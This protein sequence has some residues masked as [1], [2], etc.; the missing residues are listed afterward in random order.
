MPTGRANARQLYHEGARKVNALAPPLSLCPVARL[1][2]G[3]G[4]VCD[5]SP[6]TQHT[7]GWR[8]TVSEKS[9]AHWWSHEVWRG[10]P[11]AESEEDIGFL[12]M[13]KELTSQSSGSP[14]SL[15]IRIM[16]SLGKMPKF[17]AHQ[18]ATDQRLLEGWKGW[19][20]TTALSSRD[21]VFLVLF[22]A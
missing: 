2:A 14:A 13:S 18:R 22:L 15:C 7:S 10:F 9:R 19:I 12:T 16:R 6:I 5:Q 3:Q 1:K 11:P 8:K 17:K 20:S 4:P 21:P